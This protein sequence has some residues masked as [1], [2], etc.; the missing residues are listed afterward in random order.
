MKK[1][2]LVLG[3]CAFMHTMSPVV[4]AEEAVAP[5]TVA[6]EIM[7]TEASA[8]G[9]VVEEVAV[10]EVVEAGEVAKEATDKAAE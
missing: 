6:T 7:A 9:T 1:L 4:F 8:E 2:L 5:E 3:L 10:E